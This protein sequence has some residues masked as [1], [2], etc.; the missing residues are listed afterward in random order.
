MERL[1]AIEVAAILAKLAELARGAT[2]GIE[3]ADVLGGHDPIAA[4]R[5]RSFSEGELSGISLAEV[6][7]RELA[8][9]PVEADSNRS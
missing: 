7:I 9:W 2:V 3:N 8:G 4:E 5:Q 1:D 6:A